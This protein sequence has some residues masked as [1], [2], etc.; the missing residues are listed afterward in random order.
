MSAAKK[1]LWGA[2]FI[3]ILIALWQMIAMI[4]N[5]SYMLP[6][7]IEVLAHIWENRAEIFFVHL[8]ATMQVV[9]L[10]LMFSVL[11]GF[12]FAVIM[13]ADARI[14]KAVYP[15]LTASQ[16]IPTMCVAPVLVLWLGYSVQMRVFVVVLVNFFSVAVNVYDGLRSTNSGMTE[17]LETYGAGRGQRLLLLRLPSAMPD[18][19]TA[20][21]IAVPWSMVGAAVAE[22]LGAPAGLGMYSRNCMM[23]LD[24]AGLLAPLVVLTV[25]ALILNGILAGIEKKIF[26]WKADQQVYI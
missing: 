4:L 15:L 21:K 14:E 23:E 8:P 18:F 10:G 12:A 19:F 26:K 5:K 24:A 22:W 2:L 9:G 25:I 20:L 3:V 6:Q 11:A 7:P 17:L 16:T 13:D 1:R